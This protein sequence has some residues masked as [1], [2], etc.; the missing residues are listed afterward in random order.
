M[1]QRLA[2]V[3]KYRITKAGIN[4]E[5]MHKGWRR[6]LKGI[7]VGILVLSYGTH[8]IANAQEVGENRN[9]DTLYYLQHDIRAAYHNMHLLYEAYFNEN[10]KLE[11]Q[12]AGYVA[13]VQEWDGNE[14][15]SRTYLNEKGK[16]LTGKTVMRR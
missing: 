13:I 7:I 8:V 1:H 11:K 4:V 6:I 14:L 5:T 2:S 12:P 3:I 15:I 9:I 10:G 16:K